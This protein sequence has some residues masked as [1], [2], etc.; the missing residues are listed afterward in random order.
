MTKTIVR[1]GKLFPGTSDSALSDH[2]VIIEA[3]R[4]SYVGPTSSAPKPAAGDT[5]VDHSRHFVM[6]GLSDLHVHLSYGNALNQ[7]DIDL[8]GSM[9]YRALRAL[10]AAHRVL[11][12]GYT[13]LLDP[14]STGYVAAAVRNAVFTGMFTGP[15]I[16]CGGP[17]LSARQ[18]LN[19]FYPSWI[20]APVESS[21]VLVRSMAEAMDEIRRQTKEGYDAI[22]LSMDGIQGDKTLGLYAAFNQ[23]ET[24]AMVREAQRL[25][26]KALVH[27]RGR[28]AALYAARAGADI[29]FHASRIDEDGIRAALDN[30]CHLC[31]SLLLL[32]NNIQ[33][34]QPGDPSFAWWP[35]IQRREFADAVASLRRARDA[36]VPML[37]GSETGFAVTP[38]GEWAAKELQIM[39]EHLGM[40]PGEVLRIATSGNRKM[41]RD[42]EDYDS[43][44]VGKAADLCVV[45]G[46]PL[47]DIRVLQDPDAILEVWLDGRRVE[48]PP[49][50][51]AIPRHQT[52]LA[53]G[54][55]SRLYTRES[56]QGMALQPLGIDAAAAREG[57]RE[58]VGAK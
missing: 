12:S 46:N 7:E 25:G 27:A 11:K 41:L 40:S 28:E 49:Q 38:Y 32:V 3:G 24:T 18:S 6:P 54:M 22:K 58:S 33:F 53:Q 56:V 34:A 14:T 47:A 42:G 23:E 51:A 48:L 26:R 9:E 39:V 16:T 15:R 36:G 4:I 55:W 57:V 52:E 10:A 43:I 45:R 44:G 37:V 17:A 5:V 29:I 8:Y 13:A 35:D 19:D 30:G 31:P 50:P 21:G 1:A 20:G 2:S